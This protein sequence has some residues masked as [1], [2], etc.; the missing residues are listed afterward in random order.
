MDAAGTFLHLHQHFCGKKRTTEGRKN[1][2]NRA[3]F[4]SVRENAVVVLVEDRSDGAEH[5]EEEGLSVEDVEL[6]AHELDGPGDELVR[7]VVGVDPQ[8]AGHHEEVAVVRED[9]LELVGRVDYR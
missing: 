5:L 1:R 7:L 8:Q 4:E 9:V 2:K 3:H 6:L